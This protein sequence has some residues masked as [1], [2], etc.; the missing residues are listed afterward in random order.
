MA[1]H[2]W[3]VL[4]FL[5]LVVLV[6]VLVLVLPVLLLRDFEVLMPAMHRRHHAERTR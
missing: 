4:L 5:A 3:L 2:R 1:V 6:L